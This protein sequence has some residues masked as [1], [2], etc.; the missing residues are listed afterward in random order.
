[1]TAFYV[2]FILLSSICII[3]Q[4]RIEY[5]NEFNL[6]P[7]LNKSWIY[8][9]DENNNP[10]KAYFTLPQQYKRIKNLEESVDFSLFT[11][12]QPNGIS[13]VEAIE[14]GDTSFDPKKPT[15]MITHG[16]LS[17]G[18][19]DTCVTIRDGYLKS[20]DVNVIVMDWSDIADN[21]FYI[22]PMLAVP[23][24]ADYY[25]QFISDLIEERKV[26]PKDIHLVGHSLGA[27]ISGLV[28]YRLNGTK[29]GRVTGLDPAYPGFGY[30]NIHGE[31]ISENSA[32]FVDVIHSC[33]NFLG[34]M[35][36]IGHADFYPNG[37]TMPQPGCHYNLLEACSHGRSWQFYADS[38][39]NP[40]MPF[41]AVQ[42][43]EWEQFENKECNKTEMIVMGANTPTSAR[44]KYYLKT[45]AESPFSMGED[46]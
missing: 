27:H 31:R 23:D 34:L 40:D 37:G 17:S 28:S 9:L 26:D 8:M 12:E 29:L 22:K 42:C 35:G 10:V 15:K 44:G 32:D 21:Y 18:T 41:Y 5:K 2:S 25:A 13:I 38:L 4:G 33:G 19:A 30:I 6:F 14:L 16:W 39:N 20:S 24:V 46:M 7:Y 36:P 43:N 45:R 1:M 3:V 11:R